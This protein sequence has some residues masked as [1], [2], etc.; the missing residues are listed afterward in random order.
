MGSERSWWWVVGASMSWAGHGTV[1]QYEALLGS[2][3]YRVLGCTGL[4]GIGDW[5]NTCQLRPRQAPGRDQVA[6][7]LGWASASRRGVGLQRRLGRGLHWRDA[8]T[9]E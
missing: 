8:G 9:R 7:G 2:W 3:P 1:L 4:L 5:D 6:A